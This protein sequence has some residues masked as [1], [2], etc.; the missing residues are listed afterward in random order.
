ME[1]G[2]DAILCYTWG[3]ENSDAGHIECSHGPQVSPLCSI[4]CAI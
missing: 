4:H 2:F 1:F 3:N